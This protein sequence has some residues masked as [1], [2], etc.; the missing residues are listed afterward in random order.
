[1]LANIIIIAVLAVLFILALTKMI[2]DR[3]NG[4]PA[5]GEACGGACTDACRAAHGGR[6]VN[7]QKIKRSELRKIRKSIKAREEARE[8]AKG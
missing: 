1:M 7:G 4:I 8:A 2:R 5:C 6:S 3:R